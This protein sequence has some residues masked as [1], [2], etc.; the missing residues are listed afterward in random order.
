MYRLNGNLHIKK[1]KQTLKRR[2]AAAFGAAFL[3]GLTIEFLAS[4]AIGG[5][6]AATAA[7]LLVSR[8]TP[9]TCGNRNQDRLSL[10]LFIISDFLTLSNKEIALNN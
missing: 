9:E 4:K 6:A 5:A 8:T 1:T 10:S 3:V 7:E 2:A